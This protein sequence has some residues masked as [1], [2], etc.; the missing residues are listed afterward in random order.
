M[1]KLIFSLLGL[2]VCTLSLNAQI[3]PSKAF[4]KAKKAYSTYLYDSANNE[5]SLTEAK[6]LMG[7][8]M[9]SEEVK[10]DFMAWELQ[11]QICNSL[12][13]ADFGKY[14]AGLIENMSSEADD[15]SALAMESALEAKALALKKFQIS[16]MESLWAETGNAASSMY[17]YYITRDDYPGAFPHAYSL[18]VIQDELLGLGGTYFQVEQDF[19][20]QMFAAAFCGNRAAAPETKGLYERLIEMGSE[21]AAVYSDYF[22]IL[23]AEGDEAAALE[24]LDNAKKRFP[25]K[26]EILYAEINYFLQT[27]RYEELVDKLK[28]AIEQ[29]PENKS[30]Y[31]TLGLV[32]EQIYKSK[33]A[34][35]E[36]KEDENTLMMFDNAAK[37]F[38]LAT[39]KDPLFTD[40]IYGLGALYYNKAAQ[41]S[42]VMRGLGTSKEDFELYDKLKIEMDGLFEQSL[43]Y[44]KEVE[45]ID[46]NDRNTLIA[47]KEIFAKSGDL[48]MSTEFKNRLNVVDGGGQNESSYFKN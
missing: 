1:N 43:P 36:G 21:N 35:N 2:M 26:K 48:E 14:Q 8:A 45:S 15:Y 24:V 46:A 4:K 25:D 33:L 16:A 39:E 13:Q 32:Y 20:D 12:I 47:L 6:D 23:I 44:F 29:E 5:A 18:I 11:T 37:Y 34:A 28:L 27:N 22:A 17:S 19:E 30:L 3:E 40:A 38:T 42:E 7:I 41:I 31:S 10:A 9:E